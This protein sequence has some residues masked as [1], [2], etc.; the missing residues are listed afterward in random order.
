MKRVFDVV[1]SFLSLIVFLTLMILIGVVV[2]FDVGWPIIYTHR[3]PGIY[4]KVFVL[5]RFK[6]MNDAVGPNGKLL[7]SGKRLTRVGKF[8]KY[9]GLDDLPQLFNVI[10]GDMSIVGPRPVLIRSIPSRSANKIKRHSV[11]PGITGWTQLHNHKTLTWEEKFKLDMY[12]IE[13][14]SFQFDMKIIGLTLKKIWQRLCK[15]K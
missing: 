1:V 13:H 11:K 10:K 12:Y 14:E 9:Y 15:R 5:Y 7:P 8:L 2:L 3:C 6:T 4:E